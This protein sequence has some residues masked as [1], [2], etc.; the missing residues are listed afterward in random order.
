MDPAMLS[1]TKVVTNKQTDLFYGVAFEAVAHCR[2]SIRYAVL[3]GLRRDEVLFTN[4][5]L[6]AASGRE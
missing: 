5:D 6:P 1:A 2:G 4:P 3:P